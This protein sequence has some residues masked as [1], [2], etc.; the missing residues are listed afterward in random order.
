MKFSKFILKKIE[1]VLQFGVLFSLVLVISRC[2]PIAPSL[3]KYDYTQNSKSAPERPTLSAPKTEPTIVVNTNSSFVDTDDKITEK[4]LVDLVAKN[5]DGNQVLTLSDA[6]DEKYRKL[7]QDLK[8]RKE[9]KIE[10]K[11]ANGTIP[12]NVQIL[13]GVKVDSILRKGILTE[14]SS[15]DL[16]LKEM[17]LSYLATQIEAKLYNISSDNIATLKIGSKN[18]QS[19]LQNRTIKNLEYIKLVSS[20]DKSI[21]IKNPPELEEDSE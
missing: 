11:M 17:V 1:T 16:P 2:S 19:E 10:L 21:D 7:F 8:E 3:S 9:V 5:S 12:H 20:N 4:T 6:G 13:F 14:S 15:L 18:K